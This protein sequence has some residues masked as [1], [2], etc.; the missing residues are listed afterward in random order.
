MNSLPK[1]VLVSLTLAVVSLHAADSSNASALLLIDSA[2][3][4]K[5]TELKETTGFIEQSSDDLRNE[6]SPN[7]QL[8][9]GVKA[10]EGKKQTIYFV[11]LTTLTPPLTNS[12]GR[13]WQPTLRTNDFSWRGTN[14]NATPRHAEYV[15]PLY[16]V[17]ARVFDGT[18]RALKEGQTPMAWG[19]STNGLLDM[20]RLSLELMPR[21]T[22]TNEPAHELSDEDNDEL[23]QAMGGGFMW[24]AGMFSDFQTV[25]S[26]A[27]VWK[28]AQCAIRMPG[29]WGMIKGIFTGF[30]INLQPRL[31]EVTLTMPAKGSPVLYHLP[32]DLTSRKD[33]LT[34]VEIIVGPARGA[35]MLM[36]G[37]RSI[38]AV[39]PTKP[40]REFLAQV[41]ATGLCS[42]E[43]DASGIKS[44]VAR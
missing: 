2:F 32:V 10:V 28:K 6:W 35:E 25:P 1:I 38:R 13:N 20:C 34:D 17:R 42:E 11:Q 41:L 33:K 27:E 44:T 5:F 16:L 30:S 4:N 8:W 24:L 37:I 43:K 15:T 31:K 21:E 19:M 36:S 7:L 23:M 18:G 29:A 40:Q 14:K 26:V 9:V 39:H 3:T 12:N 22:A